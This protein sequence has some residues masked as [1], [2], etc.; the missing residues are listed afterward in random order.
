MIPQTGRS[1]HDQW[2]CVIY[3]HPST[4]A[5]VRETQLGLKNEQIL[6]IQQFARGHFTF[7]QCS[8]CVDTVPAISSAHQGG[9]REK[10]LY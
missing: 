4:A 2:H 8:H 5:A 10:Q 9:E 7:H 3:N 6:N 1:Q